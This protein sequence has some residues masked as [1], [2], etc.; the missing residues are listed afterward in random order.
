MATMVCGGDLGQRV[1]GWRHG[2][3][4][5][6][7]RGLAG[8]SF[9]GATGTQRLRVRRNQRG[10][11]RRGRG[12]SMVSSRVDQVWHRRDPVL[13]VHD[14]VLLGRPQAGRIEHASGGCRRSPVQR[15]GRPSRRGGFPLQ[16]RLWRSGL[17]AFSSVAFGLTLAYIVIDRFRVGQ[18]PIARALGQP[19]GAGAR[20]GS[21]AGEDLRATGADL[22]QAGARRRAHPHP[23][24]HAR[25]RRRASQFG[26]PAA[27][28]RPRKQASSCC[29]RCATRSTS[30]SC[31]IDA[32]EHAA[33]RP[34]CHCWRPCA[35]GWNRVLRHPTWNCTG[36]C[37]ELARI[38]RLRRIAPCGICSSWC[39]RRSRTCS[40][41]HRHA[42]CASRLRYARRGGPI[43][44]HRR[45]PRFRCRPAAAQGPAVDARTRRRDRR[46]AFAGEPARPDGG[47]HHAA[48]K[49]QLSQR[50]Q[51]GR[52]I[53]AG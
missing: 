29:R 24:R 17:A 43:D 52:F 12:A 14:S 4:L 41:M 45:R 2:A 30:S 6:P 39:S 18:C 5:L 38:A 31:P 37:E 26:D 40:S 42:C 11:R 34:Q 50:L 25:R 22:G 47:G 21:R 36:M 44:D 33:R 49:V 10:L 8:P 53:G 35:T 9:A 3:V 1:L 13:P 48:S 7:R 16:R 27:A 15:S 28:V 32:I 19:G 51:A 20:E 23:A 46:A